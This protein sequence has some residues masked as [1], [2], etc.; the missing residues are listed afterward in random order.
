MS[1]DSPPSSRILPRDYSFDPLFARA[2]V[3][4][5]PAS[6][7]LHAIP[8]VPVDW[9]LGETLLIRKKIAK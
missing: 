6:Q 4:H 9:G 1:F 2:G 3:D 7:I 5:L 8:W